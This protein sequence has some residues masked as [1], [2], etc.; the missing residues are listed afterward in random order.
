LND[1][2]ARWLRK[3]WLFAICAFSAVGIAQ[4]QYRGGIVDGLKA[5][6]NVAAPDDWVL[7]NKSTHQMC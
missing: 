6:S 3:P 4:D 5:G 2:H 7:D 1:D